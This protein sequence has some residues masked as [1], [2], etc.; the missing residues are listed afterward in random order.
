MSGNLCLGRNHCEF[1][2]LEE[3]LNPKELRIILR[4]WTT[5]S[6]CVTKHLSLGLDE[7]LIWILSNGD[8]NPKKG[9]PHCW[10]EIQ[11]WQNGKMI[12]A[13]RR[14]HISLHQVE[15]KNINNY[16]QFIAKFL[17]DRKEKAVATA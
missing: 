10:A 17:K 15:P 4:T 6:S 12:V 8:P 7:H 14:I 3:E 16:V 9:F 13:L 1:S 2:L 5:L 11:W